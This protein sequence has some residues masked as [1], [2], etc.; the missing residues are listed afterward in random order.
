MCLS[1]THLHHTT[2][3]N[4]HL[5]SNG[6]S[7]ELNPGLEFKRINCQM[8]QVRILR[9]PENLLRKIS[10]LLLCFPDFRKRDNWLLLQI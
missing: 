4:L 1:E 8:V 9:P 5:E 6:L 10:L 2:S 3:K 7:L